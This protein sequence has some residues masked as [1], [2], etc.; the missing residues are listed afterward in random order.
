MS[1]F[2]VLIAQ[3]SLF[4]KMVMIIYAEMKI[5]DQII[6]SNFDDLNKNHVED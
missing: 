2:D 6:H 4:P 1:G 3:R 5:L